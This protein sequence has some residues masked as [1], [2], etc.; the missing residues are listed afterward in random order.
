[1]PKVP[2]RM[3]LSRQEKEETKRAVG[4]RARAIRKA[5]G[6]SVTEVAERAEVPRQYVYDLEGGIR[7]SI[8]NVVAVSRAL[9]VS[10]DYV[11]GLS[12]EGPCGR[13]NG[14]THHCC[15]VAADRDACTRLEMPGLVRRADGTYADAKQGLRGAG[16]AELTSGEPI[17]LIRCG[18]YKWRGRIWKVG[19]PE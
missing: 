7:V 16:M 13:H 17:E 8:T 6:L 9:R 12:E 1:M 14:T 15:A 11:L 19:A 18:E 10:V 5:M 3:G 2:P 4:R